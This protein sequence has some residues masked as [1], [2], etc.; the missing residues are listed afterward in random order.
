M[1]LFCGPDN[2]CAICAE[3]E[4]C[5]N[6]TGCLGK[7]HCDECADKYTCSH[8]GDFDPDCAV[9]ADGDN[10]CENC[11][12]ELFTTCDDCGELVWLDDSVFVD[13]EVLCDSCADDY[14]CINC[15]EYRKD[16]KLVD[17]DYYCSSCYYN[18]F[19][20]CDDCCCVVDNDEI[21]YVQDR[22]IC[23]GC[24]DDYFF[25]ESCG[26]YYHM[27]DYGGECLC[28]DC[29]RY[30]CGPGDPII[31][32]T[33]DRNKSERCFGIEIETY[34]GEYGCRPDG[35]GCK[36]DGSILGMELVSPIMSGDEGLESIEKLYRD[37]C[38]DFCSR[39]GIH[40]HI[41]VRDLTFDERLAVIKKF[42][43]TK[44]K[45]FS[46]VDPDRLDNTFCSG[47]NPP[48]KD[49]DDYSS[50]MG[51]ID[52]DR[53]K[54]LNLTSVYS[55]GTFEVRLLEATDNVDKVTQWVTDLLAMVDKAVEEHLAVTAG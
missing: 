7:K 25:C 8:C 2:T 55:H 52:G 4:H 28:S 16:G 6:H 47:D 38:P 3:C 5:G 51:S 42:E 31:G 11:F 50:Y 9:G 12:E 22:A 1:C 27:D 46:R 15:N 21:T 17:C 13:N 45:W 53:Y 24:M 41:N 39:C 44:D 33:F 36:E 34:S 23:G 48:V 54:W 14:Y 30:E 26:D 10:Y 29:Y 43:E 18:N 37:V 19:T 20:T 35:W 49:D 32:T 40:V